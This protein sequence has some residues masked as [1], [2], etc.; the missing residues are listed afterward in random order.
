MS[1]GALDILQLLFFTLQ[2]NNSKRVSHTSLTW[3]MPYITVNLNF[4]YIFIVLATPYNI[5]RQTID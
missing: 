2:F 1:K 5:H 4:I 3:T